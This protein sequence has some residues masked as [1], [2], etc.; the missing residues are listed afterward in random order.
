MTLSAYF[1]QKSVFELHRCRARTLALATLSCRNQYAYLL[2]L[3]SDA[4]LNINSTSHITITP[5]A[6]EV[7]AFYS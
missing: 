1:M 7:T 2:G 6:F 4:S 3:P 5:S